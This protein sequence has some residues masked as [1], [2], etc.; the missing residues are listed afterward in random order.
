MSTNF[1]KISYNRIMN[2]FSSNLRQLRTNKNISQKQLAEILNTTNSS[3]CDWETGRSEPNIENII[4]LAR[5][6]EIST[7]ALL[8]LED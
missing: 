1:R 2:N 7:D 8:G 5:F 3:I 4:K 6:F